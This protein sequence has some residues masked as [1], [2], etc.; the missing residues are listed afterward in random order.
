MTRDPDFESDPK[1]QELSPRK[2]R[3]EWNRGEIKNI[4]CVDHFFVYCWINES[5][6]RSNV[7]PIQLNKSTFD[8]EINVEDDTK[9]SIQINAFEDGG[10]CRSN[11]DNWSNEISHRT[12]KGIIILI[13]HFSHLSDKKTTRN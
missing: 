9:Y 11:E 3:V 12:T 7:Q 4:D 6:T 13:L 10:C 8:V 5:E 2:I 1:I